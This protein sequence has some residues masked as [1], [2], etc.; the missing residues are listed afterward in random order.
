V[1]EGVL[2]LMKGKELASDS[3]IG[4]RV[5]LAGLCLSCSDQSVKLFDHDFH[6]GVEVGEK[7]SNTTG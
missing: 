4:W 2:L 5:N 3:T 1:A 6:P 7:K